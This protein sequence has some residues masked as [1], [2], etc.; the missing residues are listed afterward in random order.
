MSELLPPTLRREGDD[1]RFTW[2]TGASVIVRDIAAGGTNGPRG[3]VWARDDLLDVHLHAAMLNLLSTS[4]KKDFVRALAARDPARCWADMVEQVSVLATLAY[5]EG[6]PLE[7]LEPRRRPEAGQYAID[8][9]APL[10]QPTLWYGDGKTLKSYL[11]EACCQAMVTGGLVAGLKARQLTPAFLDWEWDKDEQEDRLLRLGGEATIHYQRCIVPLAEQAKAIK[12]KLDR[13]GVDFIGIDSMGLAC[14]GDPSLPEVAL[15]FF[16]AVRYLEPTAV[17]V[18]HVPKAGKDP[19]GSVYIRNS[20]R[21]GWYF[22]RAAQPGEQSATIAVVNK[23]SNVGRLQ[24]AIGVGFGF[25]DERYVTEIRRV[26]PGVV[27]RETGDLPAKDAII[28][29]LAPGKMTVSAIEDATGLRGDIVRARLA[30]LRKGNKAEKNGD[31]WFLLDSIHI[32]A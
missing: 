24:K 2:D 29:A 18:H 21:A 27:L 20:T 22:T 3:E 16:S 31:E 30:E 32:V 9:L 6:E 7:L 1:L 5:R 11:L 4:S 15:R 25:D 12:R 13:Q 28:A 14:G 19:Y 8:P 23:W 26:D 17:I 10:G